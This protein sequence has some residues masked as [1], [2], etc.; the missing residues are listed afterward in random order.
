MRYLEG[1]TSIQTT[2]QS[3][4]SIRC[5]QSRTPGT[6]PLWRH[7]GPTLLNLDGVHSYA[8]GRQLGFNA[9]RQSPHRW[10][11]FPVPDPGTSL[12]R[13]GG[14]CSGVQFCGSPVAHRWAKRAELSRHLVGTPRRNVAI[15]RWRRQ[16]QIRLDTRTS[17]H[18]TRH[19]GTYA[20]P[21]GRSGLG[22]DPAT[23]REPN[24]ARS[25]EERGSPL[26]R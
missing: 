19:I 5:Q 3:N 2:S 8:I 22:P 18:R 10:D 6:F 11:N 14:D 1:V 16:V 24:A 4:T 23:L 17:P 15:N 7:R 20:L 26:R 12:P 9:T 21:G 25:P 13:A